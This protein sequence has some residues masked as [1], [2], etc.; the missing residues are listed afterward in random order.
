MVTFVDQ[1]TLHLRAGDGG[2]GCISVKREKFK[3]LAGPDGADGGNGG[4]ISLIADANTTTLLEYHF[5]PHRSGGDGGDGAGDFRNGATG[6][7]VVL[8]VPIGT[9]VRS[10]DGKII[11]D[12]DEAGMEL[13]VAEGGQGG[14]GN[15]ALSSSKRRAPGFALLGVPGWR[16]D[17]ILEL[18]SVADVALVGY[19]S[20]GKSSLI[21]SISSAKPKIA[22]YPFTTL[23]PNLGVVQAGETRF[24]VADV[25]GL[26]EGASEGKGL[27]LQFLRHVERCAALLHVLDCATLEPNRD[28]I[29]D[30]DL[31]LNELALYE[32][33]E[34]ELPLPERPQIIALNKIDVPDGR[35]LAEFVKPELEARGYKVFLISAVTHEGLRELNFALAE[36]VKNHRDA[37]SKIP[38]RPRIQLMNHKREDNK[39]TVKKE[40]YGDGE[41]FRVI[42]AKPERWVAQTMFGNEEA[43]GYL[44]DRLAKLGLE[45][46]LLKVGAVAGSTVV[47]GAGKDGV[48][49]DWEPTIASAGELIA[50]PRGT[51]PRLDLRERR[52]NIDRRREYQEMMDARAAMREEMNKEGNPIISYEIGSVEDPDLATEDPEQAGVEEQK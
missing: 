13:V 32:V 19:P 49:F 44:G 21:A 41:I 52:T 34:G 36:L 24:T 45:D 4:T 20:A 5:S 26:I 28:P 30:L 42:G 33:P 10:A 29:S 11:T 22:D 35:E 27:G 48:I 37:K 39:F 14:L 50:A 8:N 38:A 18:K 40:S 43:V 23:H 16:G 9:V 25:P 31:I 15:A 1:V 17:V 12:L 7:D 3:P 46:E 2:D 47:I 6:K 51:D